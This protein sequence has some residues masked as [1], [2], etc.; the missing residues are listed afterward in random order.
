M[1]PTLDA[2]CVEGGVGGDAPG[3]SA[4][5]GTEVSVGMYL[6]LTWKCEV[7]AHLGLKRLIWG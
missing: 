5:A 7:G 1:Y 3:A 6:R 4:V 2:P